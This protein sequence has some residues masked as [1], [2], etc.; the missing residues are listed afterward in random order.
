[1]QNKLTFIFLLI[2]ALAFAQI[3]GYWDKER[4]TSKLVVV[5]ARDRI[6]IPLDELPEGTTKIVYRI[7]E[8]IFAS[9]N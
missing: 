6:I 7:N 1:M 8:K 3:D 2:T 5:S 4:A 9:K